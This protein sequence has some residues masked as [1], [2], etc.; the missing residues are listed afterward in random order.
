MRRRGFTLV[1]L[2]VVITIIGILMALLLPAVNSVRELMRSTLCMQRQQQ[3]AHATL[4]YTETFQEFPG[5]AK[6]IGPKPLRATWEVQLLPFV[7]RN[8]LYDS[9]TGKKPPPAG[10]TTPPPPAAKTVFLDV[11]ICPSN[12]PDTPICQGSFVGNAGSSASKELTGNGIF[13]NRNATPSLIIKPDSVKDGM[14]QTLLYS[15]NCQA[16]NW[17]GTIGNGTDLPA[18]SDADAQKYCCFVFNETDTTGTGTRR[19]NRGKN[20]TVTTAAQMTLEYARPSSQHTGGVNVVFCDGHGQFLTDS[21]DYTVYQQLMTSDSRNAAS[22]VA[23]LPP[24]NDADY[25]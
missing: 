3:W 4:T 11:L 16:Q 1:E 7:D 18:A 14:Q 2:L 24:L 9:W 10:S 25:R 6:N 13:V 22:G 20:D 19:I 17:N 23:G 12:P 8:D 21:I 15:E 5:Y